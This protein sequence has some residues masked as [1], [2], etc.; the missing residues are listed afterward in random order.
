MDL[1]GARVFLVC[2]LL[3][4][5]ASTSSLSST[6]ISPVCLALL[7]VSVLERERGREGGREVTEEPLS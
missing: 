5:V 6:S 4:V 1:L 3:V 2:V 7:W